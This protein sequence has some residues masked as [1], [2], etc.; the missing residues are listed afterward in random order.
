MSHEKSEVEA[1]RV[2]DPAMITFGGAAD[3]VPK[4]SWDVAGVWF[5]APSAAPFSSRLVSWV[6]FLLHLEQNDLFVDLIRQ[7]AH[8]I[9]FVPFD[10][11]FQK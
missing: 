11:A 7:L 5:P 8:L 3:R 1:S 2:C 6:C 10:Y 9:F 4:G